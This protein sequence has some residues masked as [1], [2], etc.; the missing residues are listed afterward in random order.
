MKMRIS[1]MAIAIPGNEAQGGFPFGVPLFPRAQSTCTKGNHMGDRS[2]KSNQ[3]QKS[4][5]DSKSAG[6]NAQKQKEIL[7]K[8]TA[9]KKN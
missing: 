4:Q 7:A 9:G 5:K 1:D 3:K 6:A 8:Q 2:P